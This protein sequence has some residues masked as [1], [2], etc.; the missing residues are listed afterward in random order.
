[1]P[2]DSNLYNNSMLEPTIS[3]SV[4][5]L[6]VTNAH[7]GA[8]A[9]EGFCISLVFPAANHSSANLECLQIN[10]ADDKWTLSVNSTAARD[11]I[12]ITILVINQLDTENLFYNRFIS[13]L[14]MFRVPCAHH[15][16]VKI[17]L[18]SIWYHHTYRC[19]DTRC[20]IIQFWPPDDDRIVLE[21]CTGI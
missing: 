7:D 20:C 17:V 10:T 11:N 9:L 13:C 1:M 15:Q 18:C 6:L 2:K 3:R 19:D 5:I 16:E 4:C 12:I 21:T 14:Y 8:Y